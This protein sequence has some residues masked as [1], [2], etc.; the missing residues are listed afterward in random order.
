MHP[1][2]LFMISILTT[3]ATFCNSIAD[4]VQKLWTFLSLLYAMFLFRWI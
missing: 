1:Q 2:E 4:I 3:S